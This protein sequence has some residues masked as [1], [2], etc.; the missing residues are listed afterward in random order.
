MG[1]DDPKY[2]N[3]TP[4]SQVQEGSRKTTEDLLGRK[5][6]TPSEVYLPVSLLPASTKRKVAGVLTRG[7][8]E[9]TG[10]PRTPW[11]SGRG[12]RVTCTPG[13][14]ETWTILPQSARRKE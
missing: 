14:S 4:K 8:R 9:L 2:K 10:G 3:V 11:G 1:P 5:S 13:Q 12:T 7:R 6:E